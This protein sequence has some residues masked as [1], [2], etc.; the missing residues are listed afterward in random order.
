MSTRRRIFKERDYNSGDGF[1]TRTW[2]PPLWHVL[3]TISFNYPAHPSASHKAHY[4]AWFT[5]MQNVLPCG[6]CRDNLTNTMELMPLKARH[7]ASREAFSRYIYTLHE[8][9]NAMLGKTSGLSYNMVRERYEHFRARCDK[10]DQVVEDIKPR[11]TGIES[12]CTESLYGIDTKC[13]M[14]MVP[15]SAKIPS[16]TIDRKCMKTRRRRP[17]TSK[18]SNRH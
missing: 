1:V 5:S 16:L 7:M 14:Q 15:L 12:G 11:A 4:R 17:S 13:V 10:K 18:K 8:K 6:K 2:G 9:V 3:H